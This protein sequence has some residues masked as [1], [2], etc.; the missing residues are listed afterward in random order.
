MNTQQLLEVTSTRHNPG[1]DPTLHIWG[2]EIPV[3]LF[4]GGVVAGILVLTAALEL[5]RG[6][7][8]RSGALKWMPFAALGLL[9]LGMGAL[10][11][12]LAHKLHV[13]RFYFAFRPT[14][15][16]SWG[17]WILILMYPAAALQGLGALG[18]TERA[19][20]KDKLSFLGGLLDWLYAK[21][22]AWRRPVLWISLAVGA[23]LG[24]YTG[25]LLGTLTA[26]FQWNS[27]VLGPLFLTSGLST[28]AA[29][30]LLFPM[31]D[32]ERHQLVRWDMLAIAVELF[33][34]GALVIGYTQSG[35]TGDLAAEN[36]LGG[37]FTAPFW[38]LVVILGL[39][40]PLA[41]EIM[42]KRRHLAF[43]V[44]VPTLILIGGYSL[45]AVLLAAGQE[46][47]FRLLGQ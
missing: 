5:V 8:P 20:L 19:W 27:A 44:M 29:F 45:R 33:L 14:S 22:D 9:S 42:E 24:A 35:L 43:T 7:K 15:P 6:E 23:G 32:G 3:Y 21:A 46:T 10:F 34:L 37:P 1:V 17:A 13:Y 28:G 38:G 16:M 2:W 36:F 40:V 31:E 47:A 30:M 12:D 4:L 41:M 26:R 18:D 39:V 11:L 25:L